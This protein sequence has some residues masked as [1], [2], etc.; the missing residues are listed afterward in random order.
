MRKLIFPLIIFCSLLITS[1]SD[2][3]I[4]DG[5]YNPKTVN[6]DT[7]EEINNG[8]DGNDNEE[9]VDENQNE[10]QEEVSYGDPKSTGISDSDCD[11]IQAID[12]EPEI[13][14]ILIEEL[15]IQSDIPE[16]YDLSN[17]M[18]PVRSQGTQ[19]MVKL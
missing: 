5:P 6:G 14:E 13:L 3:S 18:R 15:I 1:C 17:L 16:R 19:G 10:L 9:N 2:P 4:F 8:E 7:S 11:N 12:E